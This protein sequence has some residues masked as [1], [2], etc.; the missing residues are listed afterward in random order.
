MA[1]VM[2]DIHG[3]KPGV[4]TGLEIRPLLGKKRKVKRGKEWAL[5]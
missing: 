5:I 3:K 2:L 4:L 1:A